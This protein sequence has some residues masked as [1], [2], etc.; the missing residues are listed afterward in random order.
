MAVVGR[1]DE[2]S[3]HQ[4]SG[5]AWNPAKPRAAVG[6]VVSVD[7][8]ELARVT[9]N[10]HRPD[11][12]GA[13]I[14]DGHHAFKLQL[15]IAKVPPNA[16]AVRVQDAA[17]MADLDGS[18]MPI[19][20][21]LLGRLEDVSPHQISGWAWNSAD[22]AAAVRLQVYV[23]GEA[24]VTVIANRYR[25]DLERANIG[26]GRH[27]FVIDAET[28]PRPLTP[29]II[30]VVEYGTG[31][32]LE[33]SPGRLEAPLELQPAARAAIVALM[34]SPGPA[35]A[36][37]ARARFLAEQQSAI[38]QRLA[39]LDSNRRLR[40]LERTMKWR[41]RPTN[42][43]PV[44]AKRILVLDSS[45]PSRLRDPGSN[46]LVS[47]MLAFQR[48]GFEVTFAPADMLPD[49]GATDLLDAGIRVVSE[50]WA[51]AVEEVLR[52][53]R[54]EF[55]VVYLHGIAV[56]GRYLRLVRHYFPRARIIF[57]V[58]E[59]AHLS[60]LRQAAAEDRPEVLAA[61]RSVQF[62]EFLTAAGSHV[63]LTHSQAEADIVKR[64]VPSARVAV[65]S[66][67]AR[68]QADGRSFAARS[69]VALVGSFRH[70]RHVDAAVWLAE[71]IM[72]LV[73]QRSPD[74]T[75]QIAGSDMPRFLQE[76]EDPR[77]SA[78]GPVTDLAT[79][80][81]RVRVSVAPVQ[82]GA[83]LEGMVADSLAAGVPCVCSPIAGGGF[84]FGPPLDDLVAADAEAMADSI[85]RVHG[86]KALFTRYRKAG[87]D[88]VATNFTEAALDRTLRAVLE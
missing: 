57:N 77:I 56:A 17:T 79:V 33:N 55:D 38:V 14:G 83:G 37:H 23:N 78:I 15:D 24:P 11:L 65:V 61:A 41:Q 4:V 66:W 54:G 32:E 46:P 43:A 60:L 28:L 52:R 6:L 34:S 19:A 18:P 20:A 80:L 31:I 81:R 63:C 10:A 73:W 47:H 67:A 87:L 2:A 22:P 48:L 13:G 40:T 59:L 27:G 62:E 76:M 85:V 36:L 1:L 51:A 25:E 88:Y 21:R 29:A 45:T 68:T 42:P 49:D 5:W 50:P 74:I 8:T 75:C 9:A 70:P 86:N 16:R 12:A 3:V 44:L 7:G 72:P 71:T 69:G 26:F 58:G 39:D 64:A 30:R 53:Q 35:E 84:A 82:Y